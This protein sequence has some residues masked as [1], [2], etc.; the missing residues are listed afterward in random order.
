MTKRVLVQS[1]PKQGRTPEENEDSLAVAASAGRFAVADGVST[2][3]RPEVWSALLAI[4]YVRTSDDALTV[5]TLSRLATQWHEVTNLPG[6]P[7]HAYEKLGQGASCTLLGL[8]LDRQTKTYTAEAVGDTCLL[9]VRG[10]ILLHSFPLTH[11]SQFG[12]RPAQIH[13]N[14]LAE[15]APEV[16]QGSVIK[17]DMLII[18]TD[19]LAC[20]LLS[21]HEL[22]YQLTFMSHI[23]RGSKRFS[24]WV[25]RQRRVGRMA[26]DDTTV[27]VV[28]I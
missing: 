24:R 23:A 27:C 2:S 4:A 5:D 18:A 6:L 8:R 3:A 26:N 9:H 21:M 25:A 11:S 10:S 16:F 12:A 1:I 17:G 22:R 15:T 13:T 19:A 14:S 7:W 20:F 28:R